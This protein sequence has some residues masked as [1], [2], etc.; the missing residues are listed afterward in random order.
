[1]TLELTEV[2]RQTD[3]TFISLLQAV[4]LGR[5]ALVNTEGAV[6]CGSK[7]GSERSTGT[8]RRERNAS[9]PHW[10]WSLC[11]HWGPASPRVGSLSSSTGPGTEYTSGNYGQ[12]ETQELF[13]DVNTPILQ[14][15]K[16][17][18]KEVK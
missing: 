1:M 16:L 11:E 4:R 9:W 6:G 15:Q 8:Q 12:M 10:G 14:M 13:R 3:K 2:W 7:R 5:W 18:F 17:G